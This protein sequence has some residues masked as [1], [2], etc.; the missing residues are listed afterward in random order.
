MEKKN[1][2]KCEICRNEHIIPEEGFA[3]NK[4][5]QNA[6]NIKLNTLKLPPMFYSC[7]KRI[8]EATEVSNEIELITKD[9]EIHIYEYFEEIKSQVDLRREELKHKIDKKSEEVI[10]S[11][12]NTKQDCLRVSKNVSKLSTEI[13]NSKNELNTIKEQVDTFEIDDKKYEELKMTAD[14]FKGKFSKMFHE[15]KESLLINQRLLFRF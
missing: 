11:I 8:E 1:T 2:F 14:I 3:V 10:Q 6:L 12:E 4:R 13:E 5:I 9:P 15:Y 7:K